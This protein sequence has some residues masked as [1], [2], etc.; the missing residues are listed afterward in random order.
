MARSLDSVRYSTEAW[1]E[2]LKPIVPT[3]TREQV[4]KQ[5]GKGADHLL[6]ALLPPEVVTARANQIEE[7][8]DERFHRE[9]FNKVR[10]FSGV[11]SL[12]LELKKSG[13]LIAI[14]SSGKRTDIQHYLQLAEA[15]ELVD[16]VA[17]G[18]DCVSSKPSCDVYDIAVAR[19]GERLGG[20]DIIAVGDTPFDA[21]GAIGAGLI[22]IGVTS[23]GAFDYSELLQAGCKTVY[24]GISDILTVLRG[25]GLAG[26]QGNA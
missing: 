19:L 2:V 22:P 16:A 15:T 1:F 12:F 21:E 3:L 13:C 7:D 20:T 10:P 23:G 14:A 24:S 17:C 4:L 8:Q 18:D 25:G 6:P 26:I 9:Y 11:K 5:T